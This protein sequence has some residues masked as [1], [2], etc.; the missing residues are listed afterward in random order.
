MFTNIWWEHHRRLEFHQEN[1]GMHVGVLGD[2][3]SCYNRNAA[4]RR[5]NQ[6]LRET[7]SLPTL[8]HNLLTRGEQAWRFPACSDPDDVYRFW[9]GIERRGLPLA[10]HGCQSDEQFLF[11]QI[12]VTYWINKSSKVYLSFFISVICFDDHSLSFLR[13]F[14]FHSKIAFSRFIQ[15]LRSFS[16]FWWIGMFYIIS[17]CRKSKQRK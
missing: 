2:E 7:V 10:R 11:K 15:K 14:M 13:F 5:Q 9:T 17:F 16:P 1:K 8:R 12:V 3:A 6:L 4:R